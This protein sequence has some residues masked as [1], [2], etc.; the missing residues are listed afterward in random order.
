MPEPAGARPVRGF[1]VCLVRRGL[2]VV[3]IVVALTMI[4]AAGAGRAGLVTLA[5][6][7][8]ATA[9]AIAAVLCNLDAWRRPFAGDPHANALAASGQLRRNTG[10]G[11]IAYTW[12]AVTMQGLYF[13]PLTG[14]K[15]QHGWQYALV[16]ALLAAG[17]YG[18]LR[19]LQ[20]VLPGKDSRGWRGHFRLAMPLAVGQALVASGGPAALALSGKLWSMRADWAANRVFAALA[21]AIL[22]VSLCTII[23]HRRLQSSP[24]GA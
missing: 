14:L 11:A 13:T 23:S 2:T 5:A 4:T 3:A 6:G 8:F 20:P 17:S 15:W 12:G 19:T 10:L 1:N 9:A 21:V 24:G 18:F 7:A 22:A 16:M